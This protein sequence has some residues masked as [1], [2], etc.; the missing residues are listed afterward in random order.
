MFALRGQ[1]MGVGL[2]KYVFIFTNVI[3]YYIILYYVV[4]NHYSEINS[5]K[6]IL[7]VFISVVTSG[8]FV[9]GNVVANLICTTGSSP[10][11][12]YAVHSERVCV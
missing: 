10:K 5:V 9:R 7:T 12:V 11:F 2:P 6:S 4:Y 3:I 8:T 1:S